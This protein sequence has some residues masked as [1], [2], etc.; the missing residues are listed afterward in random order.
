MIQND[1]R[2]LKEGMNIPVQ[3][4]RVRRPNTFHAVK[5]PID[6]NFPR[7]EIASSEYAAPLIATAIEHSYVAGIELLCAADIVCQDRQTVVYAW[8]GHDQ[9]SSFELIFEGGG[10]ADTPLVKCDRRRPRTIPS[11]SS[12]LPAALMKT[13]KFMPIWLIELKKNRLLLFQLFRLVQNRKMAKQPLCRPR[14]CRK[15]FETAV[16]PSPESHGS[17]VRQVQQ[18]G[19]AVSASATQLLRV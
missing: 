8:G 14:Q 18:N 7:Q 4:N 5:Y 16:G 1:S 6:N 9:I 11:P 15:W 17:C 2:T 13:S 12:G 19:L 10:L 3:L